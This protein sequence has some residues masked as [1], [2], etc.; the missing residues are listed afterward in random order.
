M[1]NLQHAHSPLKEDALHVNCCMHC[2]QRP[3][4]LAQG[5]ATAH[6][7]LHVSCF[8]ASLLL[9]LLLLSLRILLVLQC[10]QHRPH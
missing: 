8:T 2:A 6:V 5:H 9:M 1:Q 10:G 3:T 4:V 7:L